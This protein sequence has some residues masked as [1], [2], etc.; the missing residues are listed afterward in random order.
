[1]VPFRANTVVVVVVV[2]VVGVKKAGGSRRAGKESRNYRAKTC[3]SV[4]IW[5]LS[6]V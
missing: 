2:V 5:M 6:D 4:L 1:M 3:I